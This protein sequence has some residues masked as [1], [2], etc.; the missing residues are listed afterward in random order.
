[1]LVNGQRLSSYGFALNTQDNFVDLNALP[2]SAVERVEVLKD[3]AS[4]VYG[5]DAIAGVVNII[6]KKNVQTAR[7][8][9]RRRPGHP[10]WFGAVSAAW[11]G[12]VGDLDSD[13]YNL[14]LSLDYFDRAHLGADER[15]LREIR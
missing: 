5:S 7:A 4:A 8:N 3:G 14:S 13:G 10:G 1:M 15:D 6:L 12:G 9:L 2:L 11:L